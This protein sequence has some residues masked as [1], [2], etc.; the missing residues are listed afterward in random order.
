[1]S[2]DVIFGM[3]RKIDANVVRMTA[4]MENVEERVADH[5]ARLRSIEQREDLAHRVGV[6][7]KHLD[8]INAEIKGLQ[9]WAWALPL[10]AIAAVG[11]AIGAITIAIVR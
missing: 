2:D 11:S 8:V 3:L 9:K 6:V 5:E 4:A 1:M 7:E 10:T